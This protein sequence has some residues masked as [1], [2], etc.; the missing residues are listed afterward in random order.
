[1][2]LKFQQAPPLRPTHFLDSNKSAPPNSKDVE[3]C[4]SSEQ[5]RPDE[6]QSVLRVRPS[7]R[8]SHHRSGYSPEMP[9]QERGSRELLALVRTQGHV[10]PNRG[11]GLGVQYTWKREQP[12]CPQ[13]ILYSGYYHGFSLNLEHVLCAL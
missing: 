5:A 12:P 13:S 2:A 6:A 1:M 7:G 8:E 10:S 11:L 9:I 4:A 3:V